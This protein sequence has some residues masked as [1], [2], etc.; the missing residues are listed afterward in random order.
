MLSKETN[1][2]RGFGFV[3]FETAAEAAHALQEMN[4]QVLFA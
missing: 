2:S 4:G 3:V 1:T